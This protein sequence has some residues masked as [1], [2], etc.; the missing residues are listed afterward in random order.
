MSELIAKLC[1]LKNSKATIERYTLMAEADKENAEAIV[2]AIQKHLIQ[3][4]LLLNN[5]RKFSRINVEN[6]EVT[7]K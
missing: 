1:D 4:A 2:G 6:T 5:F 7:S 3:V